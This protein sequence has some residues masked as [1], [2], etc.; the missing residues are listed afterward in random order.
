MRFIFH[1]LLVN[2]YEHFCPGPS[3]EIILGAAQWRRIAGGRIPRQMP[4]RPPVKNSGGQKGQNDLF[5]QK[6][7][8]DALDPRNP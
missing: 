3:L 2:I 5:D 6:G 4:P 7:Q 8:N 1:T